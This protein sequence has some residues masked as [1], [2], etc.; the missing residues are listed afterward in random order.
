MYAETAFAGVC[1][2]ALS[3]RGRVAVLILHE[4]LETLAREQDLQSHHKEKN[5]NIFFWKR[6]LNGTY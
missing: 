5:E 1:L 2:S 4:L 3:A 6:E